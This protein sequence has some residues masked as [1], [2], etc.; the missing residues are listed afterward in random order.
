M[1]PSGAQHTT[2][3]CR[4]A[5]ALATTSIFQ[6]GA[7]DGSGVDGGTRAMPP[8]TCETQMAA[9]IRTL[10]ATKPRCP[11]CRLPVRKRVF[12]GFAFVRGCSR[13]SNSNWFTEWA[14]TQSFEALAGTVKSYSWAATADS[15]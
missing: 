4:S 7:T 2:E 5:G 12:E 6:P 9:N 15:A 13:G 8:L 3:G 11:Q 1:R 14:A 10:I